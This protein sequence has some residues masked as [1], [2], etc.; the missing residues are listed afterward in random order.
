MMNSKRYPVNNYVPLK[1]QND[2][3][4]ENLH[5]L[6]TRLK[7]MTFDEIIR[8][9]DYHF[10]NSF[11]TDFDLIHHQC[12]GDSF[13]F[14]RKHYETIYSSDLKENISKNDLRRDFVSSAIKS[15][16]KDLHI[17]KQ[18]VEEHF[19]KDLEKNGVFLSSLRKRANQKKKDR[20]R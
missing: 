13:N 18:V 4:K 16:R 12:R 3:G 17:E 19:K 20:L 1:I 8:D 14:S 2:R 7:Q 6:D 9:P 15:E 5:D 11:V 10:E